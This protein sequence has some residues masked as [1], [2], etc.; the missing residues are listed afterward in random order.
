MPL[1]FFSTFQVKIQWRKI[2]IFLS[3]NCIQSWRKWLQKESYSKVVLKKFKDCPC[4]KNKLRVNFVIQCQFF[5]FF[6]LKKAT[7]KRGSVALRP[8]Q[9]PFREIAWDRRK[10]QIQ[11]AH[12]RKRSSRRRESSW[13][14]VLLHKMEEK[15][16]STL[17]A[18]RVK[19]PLLQVKPRNH[20]RRR[21]G[22]KWK[23]EVE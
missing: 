10:A 4:V 1:W 9:V 14:F 18:K 2:S 13:Q 12:R 8:D 7:R 16:L 3:K 15:I 23:L 21:S 11:N 19:K 6:Y 17:L 5:Y 20:K 22:Y